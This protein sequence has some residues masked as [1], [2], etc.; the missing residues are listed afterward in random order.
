MAITVDSL[1]SA[2]ASAQ[3]LI[4]QK[5]TTAAKSAGAFQ[6]CWLAA[7]NPGAGS[8]APAY[9]AGS[10]YTCSKTTNGAIVNY[11]N[12]A[13][14]GLVNRIGRAQASSAIIGKL[15]LVDRLWSCSGMGFAASTYSVTTPGS[16]PARIT[17]NGVGVEAW[18]EQFV[19]AGNAS[20][21]L[22]LNY[23]NVADASKAGVIAAVVSAPVA[24]QMQP[25]PLQVGDTGIRSVVSAVNS[26]TWTSGT[27]GITLAKRIVEIPIP[28]AG[29]GE[30][31]DYAAAALA[32]VPDDACLMGIWQAGATTATFIDAGFAVLDVG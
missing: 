3:R 17:D 13:G 11:A 15:I 32:R 4:F 28:L 20:G 10:G 1:A 2:L 14:G 5:T 22:T 6:S 31:L 18:V 26:A 27:F 30:V 25:I 16:L 23:K 21:T 8:A 19:A 24:G 29:V 12:S 9:T 7:G